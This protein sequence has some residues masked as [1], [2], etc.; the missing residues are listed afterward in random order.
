MGMTGNGLIRETAFAEMSKPEGKTAIMKLSVVAVKKVAIIIFAIPALAIAI[1]VPTSSGAAVTSADEAASL[2]KAKCAS[3]H[4][5]DGSGNTAKGKE[6]KVR[7]LRAPEVQKMSD[8]QF[9]EIIARGKGKMPGYEKSLGK[10]KVQ[11]LAAYSRE[12][13]KKR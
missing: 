7:D 10:E 12:L 1:S 4:G 5:V 9:L 13:S 3:C 11:Q 6:L 8:A 2:Y